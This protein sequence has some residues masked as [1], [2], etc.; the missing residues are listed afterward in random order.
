MVTIAEAKYAWGKKQRR[1]GLEDSIEGG[2]HMVR[3]LW[4]QHAQ[5]EDWG[6]FLI[7]TRNAF[8]EQNRTTMLCAVRHEWPSGMQFAF[9]CY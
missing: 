2:I 5:E 6:F 1:R 7:D 4:Q 9:N 3:I 8:N